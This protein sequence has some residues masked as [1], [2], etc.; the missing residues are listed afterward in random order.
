MIQNAV[1]SHTFVLQT[2]LLSFI[3]F[4]SFV[5]FSIQPDDKEA[6]AAAKREVAVVPLAGAFPDPCCHRCHVDPV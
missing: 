6:V 2:H 5:C 3:S 1:L 4:V